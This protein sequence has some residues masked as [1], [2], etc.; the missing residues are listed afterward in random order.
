MPYY[1]SYD[2]GTA[3]SR[4]GKGGFAVALVAL[5]AMTLLTGSTQPAADS[6]GLCFPA[7]ETWKTDPVL[8]MWLGM[9]FT[10][11]LAIYAIAITKHFNFLPAGNLLYASVLLLL[12]GSTPGVTGSLNSGVLMLGGVLICNNLLFALYGRRNAAEGVFLIFSTLSWGAT[13]QSAF[14][15]L[16]PAYLLGAIFLRSMRLRET[17]AMLLGTAAPFWILLGTGLTTF[18][19]FRW[20][21]FNPVF[22]MSQ[23]SAETFRL[24]ITSGICALIFLFLLAANMT[25]HNSSGVVTRAR[26]SHINTLGFILLC[27]II[28]D[29]SDITVYLP[30]F[31]LCTGYEMSLW[32]TRLKPLQRGYIFPAMLL[33]FTALYVLYRLL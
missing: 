31:F 18:D 28:A 21:F 29:F 17:V 9:A 1:D 6:S 33:A 26:W 8:S 32:S 23:P 3:F 2:N 14:L 27:L 11:A 4:A 22:C 16:M 30:A 12:C 24:M 19:S 20:P 7:I 13:V 25:R 5:A 10:A 15:L